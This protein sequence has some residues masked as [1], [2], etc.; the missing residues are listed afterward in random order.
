MSN[1]APQAAGTD[2]EG[3]QRT[4]DMQQA[5][6]QSTGLAGGTVTAKIAETRPEVKTVDPWR[7]IEKHGALNAEI[8]TILEAEAAEGV[9]VAERRKDTPWEGDTAHRRRNARKVVTPVKNSGH[10][11]SIFDAKTGERRRRA[12]EVVARTRR[13]RLSRAG[14][15]SGTEI[16]GL[17]DAMTGL[18]LSK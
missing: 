16:S 4:L 7:T 8:F 18:K 13:R 11:D 3:A 6:Q 2:P 10:I 14:L 1:K 15:K 9:R 17:L 12:R 5:M